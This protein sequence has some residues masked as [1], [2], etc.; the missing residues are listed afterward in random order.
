MS[1]RTAAYGL[2]AT[3]G[4]RNAL[5]SVDGGVSLDVRSETGLAEG[6]YASFNNSAN[7]LMAGHGDVTVDVRGVTGATGL[8]AS[9]SG[10]NTLTASDGDVKVSVAASQA[11]KNAASLNSPHAHS[12]LQ[13]QMSATAL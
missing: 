6:M 9:L 8:Y 2:S 7:T 10:V 5:L 1:A 11:N 13:N 3:N 4:G 12:N